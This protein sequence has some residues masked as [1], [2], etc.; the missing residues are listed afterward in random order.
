MLWPRPVGA[1]ELCSLT[2][3]LSL[4][5]LPRAQTYVCSPGLLIKALA[6]V[7]EELLAHLVALKAS[8]RQAGKQLVTGAEAN[9]QMKAD[10]DS[11]HLRLQNVLYEKLHLLKE[12]AACNQFRAKTDDMAL[13]SAAELSPELQTDDPHQQMLNR[14][15]AER[16]E[17][18]RLVDQLEELSQRQSAMKALNKQKA[19]KLKQLPRAINRLAEVAS[20]VSNVFS[21]HQDNA[22][23]AGS[24]DPR[25]AALPLPLFVFYETTTAFIQLETEPSGLHVSIEGEASAVPNFDEAVAGLISVKTSVQ[26]G[27]QRD[28]E[29]DNSSDSPAAVQ[30]NTP[31]PLTLKL[32]VKTAKV[33]VAWTLRWYPVVDMVTVEQDP[34]PGLLEDALSHLYVNDTGTEIVNTRIA[35]QE[36][37][38]RSA[39]VDD[40]LS[41]RQRAYRWLQICSGLVEGSASR[42]KRLRAANQVLMDILQRVEDR[43]ALQ[44]YCASLDVGR[45]PSLPNAKQHFPLKRTSTLKSCERLNSDGATVNGQALAAKYKL[46]ITNSGMPF[47]VQVAIP[48]SYPVLLPHFRLS[49]TQAARDMMNVHESN[50][51]AIAMEVNEHIPELLKID[52]APAHTV[53]AYQLRRLLM[54]VDLLVEVEDRRSDRGNFKGQ[55]FATSTISVDGVLPFKWNPD[56]GEEGLFEHR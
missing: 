5:S 44:Y 38:A 6:A 23:P 25:A 10:I 48:A 28:D 55:L 11:V 39:T 19:S 32:S 29:E 56:L 50:L 17:R 43:R 53:L 16:R 9:A 21:R 40:L 46:T 3:P 35:L 2:L 52:R 31:H 47:E 42:A 14:I 33:Q 7:H 4:L 24:N 34:A 12:T 27:H 18:E 1:V 41:E 26:S 8:V 37:V 30:A 45:L 20:D 36:A 13:I 51:A 54:C 49:L 15:E 22:L